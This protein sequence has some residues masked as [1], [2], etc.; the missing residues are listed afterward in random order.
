MASDQPAN[1]AGLRSITSLRGAFFALLLAFLAG[2]EA[3]AEQPG[4]RVVAVELY[5]SQACK[6]CPP[7]VEHL[8]ELA[9]RKDIVALS[10]HID[11][12][13][14]LTHRK[15]GRW[16]D[17]LADQSFSARQRYYNRSIRKRGTVFTP[18]IIIDGA[19]SEIGS[20]REAVAKQILERRA[21]PAAASISFDVKNGKISTRIELASARE[22]NAVLV[23]FHDQVETKITKGDNAGLSFREVNVVS[24][25]TTLGTITGRADEFSF[26]APKPGAGCA[27]LAQAKLD[28]AILAAAY[29]PTEN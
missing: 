27:V 5:L 22:A 9:A 3:Y 17:P 15:H 19:A 8:A 14:V 1:E 12:W 24:D 4:G 6:S 20:N 10:W 11:Y 29:C 16:L 28:G 18:Q 23:R 21:L 26:G 13:N 2:P 25:F 7:A